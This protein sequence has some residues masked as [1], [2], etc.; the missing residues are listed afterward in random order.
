MGSVPRDPVKLLC[1]LRGKFPDLQVCL[2]AFKVWLPFWEV[3]VACINILA[4]I[5]IDIFKTLLCI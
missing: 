1:I 2:F 5:D 3:L 4:D